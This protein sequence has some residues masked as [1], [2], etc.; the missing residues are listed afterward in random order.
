MQIATLNYQYGPKD[1]YSSDSK[2]KAQHRHILTTFTS[3]QKKSKQQRTFQPDVSLMSSNSLPPIQK[4][5]KRPN[6]IRVNGSGLQS[7]K[8]N[9]KFQS[10]LR[11][12]SRAR[13]RHSNRSD[14]QRTRSQSVCLDL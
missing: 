6:S 5:G 2:S 4:S 3:P 7:S 1:K 8:A 11:Q 12:P 14:L 13:S 9:D 10:S